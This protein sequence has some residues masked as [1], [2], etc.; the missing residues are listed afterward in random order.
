[1][2]I[3]SPTTAFGA[4]LG[5]IAMHAAGLFA[6]TSD[7][8]V[9]FDVTYPDRDTNE[10]GKGHTDTVTVNRLGVVVSAVTKDA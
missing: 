2:L 6:Q 9:T 1:M 10:I 7:E 3:Q 8:T 4:Q 5:E